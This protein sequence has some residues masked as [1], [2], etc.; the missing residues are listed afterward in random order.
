MHGHWRRAVWICAL[1]AVLCLAVSA[2]AARVPLRGDFPPGAGAAAVPVC[3]GIPLPKG[4]IDSADRVRLL[5]A[6]GREVDCQVSATAHWPGGTIKWLRIDAVLR[7]ADARS[8]TLELGPGV[9]RSPVTEAVRAEAFGPGVR[10]T[11]GGVSAKVRRNGAILEA[12]TLGGEPLVAEGAPARLVVHTLRIGDGRSGEALPAHTCVCRD[13]NARID[14]GQPRIDEL[15]VESPGP[16]R[17]TIRLRGHVLLPHF[18]QT[19]PQEVRR[20]EPPGRMPF[21]LRLSFY[22]N[23]PV[24]LGQHQIVFSGEPDCDFIARWSIELPGAAGPRGRLVLEPGVELDVAGG[25]VS[26]APQQTRL[27]WAPTKS[28]F[29]LIRQG[30]EN[31]PCAIGQAG[32]AAWIDFWPPEAGVWDLRRY[33]REWACG[34]SGNTRDAARMLR[35]ARWAARGLAKSHDFVIYAGGAAHG[36]APPIV[37]SLAAR[38]L[39][40]APPAWYASTNALGPFAPEQTAGELAA[41]DALTRRR[42]DYG[43]YCQDLF[44]WHGKLEYGFWQTR[45][46]QIHRSDRWE[47]DY[48]RWGWSLNDGAGRIGHALMLQYLRTLERR[49][50]EAGAAFCRANYD[51]AMVHTAQH[52]ENAGG[53]WTVRGCTHRHNVQPFGCPYIGMRGSNPQ[54]QRILHL[55][56]GDGA[57]ADGLE[58]VAEA[59]FR[60]ATDQRWRLGVSGGSDGQGSAACAM[61]WK[62]ETAG[63]EK[64]LTACRTILDRSGLIPPADAKRLGYG[65]DFGLFHAAAE[66]AELADDEAFRRRV[67]EVAR[68]G[69]RDDKPERFLHAIAMAYR[70]TKDRALADALAKTL[71]KLAQIDPP[72]LAELPVKLWPGHAGYRT[73]ELRANLIRDYPYAIGVLSPAAPPG[74]WPQPAPSAKPVPA[75]LPA[76]WYRPGGTQKPSD[77]APAP[78]RLAATQAADGGWKLQAGKASWTVRRAVCDAVDI[79]GASPLAEPVVP[80]IAPAKVQG[81]DVRLASKLQLCRGRVEQVQPSGNVLSVRGQAGPCAFEARLWTASAD[82]TPSV[83]VETILHVPPG[84]GHVAS[85]GLLVPLRLGKDAHA[86]QTTAPGAFR[87]E[88]CRLDQNDER[89]PNWL[90]SEYNWG[91][92]AALWPKWRLS[93]ISVGPGAFYRIWRASRA[94]CSPVFCDQGEGAAAWLDLTDRGASPRWGLTV[95]H[96]RLSSPADDVGR[97]AVRANLETGLVEVQFHDAAAEPLL[98]GEDGAVLRGAADVIFHDGWRPPLSKPELTASQYERF[99]DDLDYGGN[100]GLLALRH[101]VSTTH[102]VRGR[103]WAEKVR[104]LG[105]EPREILYGMQWRDA[106]AGHCK[107][108]G[109]PWDGEDL[110]GSV[111]RV[112]RYYRR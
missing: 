7:P 22:R 26:V 30:W 93:G 24:V 31:R 9:R 92:G 102:M 70:F 61:L 107:K 78:G 49:Y 45:Y 108:I 29:L 86:V 41:L 60:Y 47:R 77:M 91:E 28:G 23:C 32:G 81:S 98:V 72:S 11:G 110:E 6:D 94:D 48:G 58:T 82:G 69:I 36:A 57:I 103:Q 80:Y 5:A 109:V 40:V 100:F 15:L 84:S 46:G 33:A 18:G 27:C 59:C 38:A 83:R 112:I 111:Q 44:R 64:Y 21:S 35:Y 3:G 79:G 90:T 101:R 87:L 75:E 1:L 50:L 13:P 52:L 37:R 54:A 71:A 85:W 39:L 2:R 19:L 14:V 20:R 104:D 16:I 99:L 8:L 43:L 51:T 56:T 4:A 34:E 63:D 76:D 105:I 74:S 68:L 66:Y 55:L 96:L 10:L 17:A 97:R 89:I 62:Y 53:W 12:C 106:L 67:A 65:P 95:R 73:N 42:L 88:R 25:K